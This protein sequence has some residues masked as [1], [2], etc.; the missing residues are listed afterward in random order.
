MENRIYDVMILGAGPAGLAAGLYAGR[1]KLSTLI[2]EKGID[3][4]QIALTHEIENYPGQAKIDGERGQELI[5]PMTAQCRKFGCVRV[6]DTVTACD[7][8]SPVKKLIGERGVYQA[9]SVII[10]T[11]AMTRFIGCRNEAKY[12]GRGVSYCAVCDANFFEGLEVYVVGGSAAAAEEALYLAKFARKLTVLHKGSRL[13][14]TPAQRQKLEDD[15]KISVL[16][17]TEVVDLGG[18]DV[19]SEIVVRNTE[20]G[21]ETTLRA[22]RD[23]GLFGL[24]CFT[25]RKTTGM[26]EGILD[27]ED[28][29]GYIRTNE[30]METNIPGV[31]AAG[32]VRVTPLRQV[33]TACADGAIAAMQC[34]KFVSRLKKESGI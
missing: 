2:I 20:T 14:V 34:E 25:G 13:S 21:E 15:P 6:Q 19:L 4:G 1:A 33:V 3:G 7:F 11:G 27:M 30:K 9:Y 29:T 12:L 5:A 18:D 22:D 8:S 17:D 32:D 10:C 24:F 26:F 16:C 31:C 23:D 28:K